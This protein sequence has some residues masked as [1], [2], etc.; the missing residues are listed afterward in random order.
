VDTKLVRLLLS[1]YLSLLLTVIAGRQ[2]NNYSNSNH[3]KFQLVTNSSITPV[4]ISSWSTALVAVD[5]NPAWVDPR[6]H[7]PNDQKYIFP[8][9]GIFIAVNEMRCAR[10]FT[11]WQA[12]E[13]ACIYRLV[14]SSAATPLSNQE[15]HDILLVTSRPK[16]RPQNQPLLGNMPIAFLALQSMSWTSTSMTCRS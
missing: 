8:E 12:I 10:Y 13:P 9:P 3:D 16:L 4:P 14:S 7:S 15:W 11:M 6:H 1:L 5:Q 2:N